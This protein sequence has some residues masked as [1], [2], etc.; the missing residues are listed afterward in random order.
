MN[1][2]RLGRTLVWAWAILLLGGVLGSAWGAEGFPDPNPVFEGGTVGRRRPELVVDRGARDAPNDQREVLAQAAVR[3]LA[4]RFGDRRTRAAQ[5]GGQ[6][7]QHIGAH[8][9]VDAVARD[10]K[11]K[12]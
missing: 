6:V 4:G 12:C 11:R 9:D 7:N 1:R 5:C 3:D 10:R 8:H 2:L